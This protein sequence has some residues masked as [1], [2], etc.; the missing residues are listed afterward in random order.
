MGLPQLLFAALF[1]P[2][3]CGKHAFNDASLMGDTG[4]PI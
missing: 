1:F 3:G 2:F 4:D